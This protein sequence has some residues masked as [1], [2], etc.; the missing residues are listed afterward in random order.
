MA[1]ESR[2]RDLTAS[3]KRIVGQ[4]LGD[5]YT[6]VA[7]ALH[8]FLKEFNGVHEKCAVV[9]GSKFS[10]ATADHEDDRARYVVNYAVEG[11]QVCVIKLPNI[12][13]SER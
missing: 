8:R 4:H 3:V 12:E 5:R 1:D 13:E 2:C 10:V 6:Q 11:V 9:V 7:D